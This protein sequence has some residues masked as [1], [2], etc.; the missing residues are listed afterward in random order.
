MKKLIFLT[1]LLLKANPIQTEFQA[2]VR[3][4]CSSDSISIFLRTT[5]PFEGLIKTQNA[6]TKNIEKCQT[7]GIG[8]NV[9][10]LKLDLNS[11]DCGIQYDTETN[12]YWVNIDIHSHP[13]LIV[14]GDKSLKITC[15]IDPNVNISSNVNDEEE[16]RDYEMRLLS[17]RLPVDVVKYSQPYTLQIR[18]LSSQLP[19]YFIGQC[20]A[21]GGNQSVQLTDT[22]GCALFKSIMS[23]FA[24]RDYV[25]EA[26][27]PSMF[28][29]PAAMKLEITCAVID[30]D[31]K[32]CGERNCAS[33]SVKLLEKTT[34]SLESE[35]TRKVT[36]VVDIYQDHIV[37]STTSMPSSAEVRT[38]TT[39]VV[40]S[41]IL[42]DDP[43]EVLKDSPI[44]STQHCISQYDFKTIYAL[45]LFLA[46]CSIVGFTMNIVLCIMLRRK[47]AKLN[48]KK[49]VPSEIIPIPKST[50]NHPDFWIMENAKQPEMYESPYASVRNPTSEYGLHSSESGSN[51]IYRRPHIIPPEVRHS[52]S[53]FMTHSTTMET[54][55]DSQTSTSYH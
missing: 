42:A 8:T 13:I 54:D 4:T 30:C 20:I 21:R 23:D 11:D 19:N 12:T 35:D 26:E 44:H 18:P 55:L 52:N 45:C 9:A 40:P 48:E 53:T 43:E 14:E 1:L 22:I 32:S 28:R 27:I 38:T 15:N 6:T 17:N 24:R 33:E 2:D 49:K 34:A 39:T 31:G 36:L 37:S 51:E 16:N 7:L 10:V 46:V 29:F 50:V 47:S 5:K 3:W 25:E 41:L